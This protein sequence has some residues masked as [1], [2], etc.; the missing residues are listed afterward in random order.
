MVRDLQ[1][2]EA[3]THAYRSCTI[4]RDRQELRKR[5]RKLAWEKRAVG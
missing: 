2:G 4:A 1:D 3:Q 5:I